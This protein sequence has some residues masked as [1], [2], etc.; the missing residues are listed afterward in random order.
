M[1]GRLRG[2]S[3]HGRTLRKIWAVLRARPSWRASIRLTETD[4][5][6]YGLWFTG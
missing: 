1:E 6:V 2:L 4:W 5:C 3:C